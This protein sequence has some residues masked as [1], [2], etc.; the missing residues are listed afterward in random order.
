MYMAYKLRLPPLINRLHAFVSAAGLF[1]TG[2]LADEAKVC[3][4][5]SARVLGAMTMT[6]APFSEAWVRSALQQQLSFDP[7]HPA[8][9]LLGVAPSGQSGPVPFAVAAGLTPCLLYTS[10]ASQDL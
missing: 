9:A 6:Q 4:V 2:T 1:P 8:C 7:T 5:F 10:Y 3:Q